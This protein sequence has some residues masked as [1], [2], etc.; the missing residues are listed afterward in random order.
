MP[1]IRHQFI[2]EDFFI[3][4]WEI[5]HLF[6]GTF[7]PMPANGGSEGQKVNYFYGRERNQTWK[8]LSE[9][10]QI[11]F[12]VNA[13][14]FK[15]KLVESKIACMDMLNSVICEDAL[16]PDILGQG[17]KDAAIINNKV[18]RTYNTQSITETI[19][20]NSGII[21]Y[22]TWGKGSSIKEW[23]IETEK[24]KNITPLASPSLAAK[25]PKGTKKYEYML[26]NWKKNIL[27]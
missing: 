13:K 25:V 26:E 11:T 6:L 5:K 8:L 21:V 22:S 24:I 10:F 18:K 23:I 12:D 15:Q 27:I 20:K 7:N 3:P 2:N 4:K 14:D 1:T 9:I 17:F 19:Q 16:L